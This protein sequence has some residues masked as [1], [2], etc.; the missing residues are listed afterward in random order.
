MIKKFDKTNLKTVREDLN[1]ILSKYAKE[2]NLEIKLGNIS[3][4]AG[5]FTTKME[6]KV[7]GVK[8]IQDVWLDDAMRKF[9]FVKTSKCGKTLVG[10]NPRAGKYPY[11]FEDAG[12]TYKC[13]H[14]SAEKYF[15]ISNFYDKS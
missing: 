8:S 5:A 11:I 4:S 12:K 7:I 2:N 15:K 3:F 13:S 6:A 10:F 1:A 9:A 14:T